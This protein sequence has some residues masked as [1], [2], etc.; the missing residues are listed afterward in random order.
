MGTVLIVEDDKSFQLNLTE[1]FK[2]YKD[3]F[4]TVVANDGLEALTILNKQTVDLVLTDLKMPRMDGFELMAH[5]SSNY[6]EIPVIVMTAF[7]TPDMEENLRGMGAF[8]YIE[9]PI[10]FL[11]L[12]EK[13][14]SGLESTSQ[15][16]VTG[17]SLTSFLQ[18]LE[19]DKKSCTLTIH[20]GS[21]TGTIY[22]SQGDLIDAV[23]RNLT[24]L[25]AAFEIIGWDD[26][27]IE[28]GNS[29]QI[30]AREINEPL[31]YVLL[32]AARR[33][34]EQHAVQSA[35][36]QSPPDT[37]PEPQPVTTTPPQ[38]PVQQA[39]AAAPARPTAPVATA[40]KRPI[41]QFISLL[42][43]KPEISGYILLSKAGKVILHKTV[44]PEQLGAFIT[45]MAAAGEEIKKALGTRGG[46]QFILLTLKDEDNIL[47]LTGKQLVIGINL[48]DATQPELLADRLRQALNQVTL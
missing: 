5:L 17:V 18:L 46:R 16:F 44:A 29:C 22:F 7:G 13:I 23:S 37:Q 47:I 39:A 25:E 10:D 26:V 3:R 34:D 28:I 14:I 27:K 41:D 1:G 8:Q 48:T 19:L 31:G 45:Y 20:F 12:V 38:P 2:A 35:P 40:A 11:S 4:Q 24:G 6:P 15:G 43:S 36:P 21:E 33:K 30:N 9:K 42:N 32:E